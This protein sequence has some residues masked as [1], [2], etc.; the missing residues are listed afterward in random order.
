VTPSKN[1]TAPGAADGDTV[2]VRVSGCP[3]TTPFAE[4]TSTVVVDSAAWAEH[5]KA[6]HNSNRL[7]MNIRITESPGRSAALLPD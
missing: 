1:A 5:A 2:A 6:I 7:C 4:S 3:Y